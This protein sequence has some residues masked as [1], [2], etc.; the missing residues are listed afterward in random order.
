VSP[1]AKDVYRFIPSR[2]YISARVSAELARVAL[3]EIGGGGLGT[4]DRSELG[5]L[6][7]YVELGRIATAASWSSSTRRVE[8]S[9]GA[10]RRRVGQA[11]V[12]HAADCAAVCR[13]GPPCRSRCSAPLRRWISQSAKSVFVMMTLFAKDWDGEA[14]PPLPVSADRGRLRGSDLHRLRD[15]HRSDLGG[16][17]PPP[18]ARAERLELQEGVRRRTAPN[19]PGRQKSGFRA[20]RRPR[21][22]TRTETRCLGV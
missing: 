13:D 14:R 17:R 22:E 1:L 8:R 4:D 5:V 21:I 15:D 11:T 6:A 9:P 12:R 18:R 3:G 2:I 20:N 10:G 7:P 19:A 16:G